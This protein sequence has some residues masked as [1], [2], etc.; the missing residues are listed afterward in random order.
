VLY[1]ALKSMKLQANIIEGLSSGTAEKTSTDS[2]PSVVKNN[3]SVI[4]DSLTITK[5]RQ[6]Y[7]DV[8]INLET[9]AG[10]SMISA[11][12]NN[13][14][15]ISKDPASADAQKVITIVNNLKLFKDSL[16]DTMV[17]LDKL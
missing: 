13:A 2:L 14:E 15:T 3:T 8:I 5:Y 6:V 4:E 7:E 12:A 17:V 10:I 11:I 16:N 1:V 9:S